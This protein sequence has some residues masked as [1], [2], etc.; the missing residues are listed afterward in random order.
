MLLHIVRIDQDATQ[1]AKP[2][3]GWQVRYARP[4]KAVQTKLFSDG[5]YNGERPA[6]KRATLYAKDR[7][8]HLVSRYAGDVWARYQQASF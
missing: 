8:D 1:T 4:R 2:I 6:L 7:A 5:K 3:H